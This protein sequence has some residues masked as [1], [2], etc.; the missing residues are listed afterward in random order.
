MPLEPWGKP[1]KE[2]VLQR[3]QGKQL[4]RL[5]TKQRPDGVAE[6]VVFASP[7]G[8]R[9]LSM[10]MAVADVMH[11]PREQAVYFVSQPDEKH[12]GKPPCQHVYEMVKASRSLVL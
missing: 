2:L 3:E 7:G 5:L 9:A 11:L 12:A 8:E 4:W 6:V 10:A 1:P